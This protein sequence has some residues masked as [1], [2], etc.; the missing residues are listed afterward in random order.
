MV[1]GWA[2]FGSRP[3]AKIGR[4][5]CKKLSEDLLKPLPDF[6]RNQVVVRAP[7]AANYLLVLGVKG[8]GWDQCKEMREVLSLEVQHNGMHIRATR[9]CRVISTQERHVEQHVLCRVLPE[10]ERSQF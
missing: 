1:C 8:G 7:F 10:E 3:S 4:V 6:L 9:V 2:P 5:E